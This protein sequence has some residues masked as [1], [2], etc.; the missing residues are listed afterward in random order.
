MAE[1]SPASV[2]I[3]PIDTSRLQRLL[4]TPD[5]TWLVD[6]VVERIAAGAPAEEGIVSLAEPGA[7]QRRAVERLLGRPP[8]RG[9]SLTVRLADVD[10]VLRESGISP[11]GLAEAVIAL[12]GPARV[13]RE[14]AAAAQAEWE[15]AHEPLARLAGDRPQLMPWLARVRATGLL[16]R[17]APDPDVGAALAVQAVRVLAVLPHTG[18][19]RAVLAAHTVGDAHALDDGRPLT[20]FVLSAI[21]EL[22]GL[23]PADTAGAEGRRAA[24]AALGVAT[25]D[26]SSRVLMLNVPPLPGDDQ[27]LSRLLAASGA[28]GEPLVV[29]LRMLAGSPTPTADHDLSR[30]IVSV[31]ENPT[32]VSAAA[33]ELGPGCPPLVCLEGVPSVAAK[34][35]LRWL[36]GRGA[37]LRYH[38]D[39]D[40]G[41]IRIAAG[42]FELADLAGNPAAPW[43]FDST[44][45]LDAVTRGLGTPLPSA[46]PRDTPWD[47]GLR[48]H[49]EAHAIRVEE[50]HVIAQLLADLAETGERRGAG[51]S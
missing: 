39:F 16:K 46:K 18:T 15:S 17:Q 19:V 14:D 24:W 4:G 20:S 9:R 49:L 6:R 26:L 1:D 22:T 43:R 11:N 23:S 31:C 47:P 8:G 29:T 2:E 12:R 21:R 35:L 3:S 42:V 37:H 48:H 45:Y 13:R 50:E 30:T 51:H 44:A 38:G 25:D 36:L 27:A 7:E 33:T 40:W 28:D 32:V 41:G 10:A 5:L 34:R